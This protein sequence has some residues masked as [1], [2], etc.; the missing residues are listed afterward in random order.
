MQNRPTGA[1]P[2]NPAAAKAAVGATPAKPSPYDLNVE[3][4]S[5]G[6]VR[7]IPP[8]TSPQDNSAQSAARAALMKTMGGTNTPGPAR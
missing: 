7:V 6:S 1:N 3:V 4:G 2:S 8:P 5:D